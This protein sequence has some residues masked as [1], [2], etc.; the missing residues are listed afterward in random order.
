MLNTLDIKANAM[1]ISDVKCL[2]R[3]LNV[4]VMKSLDLIWRVPCV[5]GVMDVVFG[6]YCYV[7]NCRLTPAS[8]H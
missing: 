2:C 1:N 3:G 8:T 5:W 6:C 7:M 4:S